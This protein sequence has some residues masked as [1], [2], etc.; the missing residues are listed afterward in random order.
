MM[1]AD[2]STAKAVRS[3]SRKGLLVLLEPTGAQPQW[4]VVTLLFQH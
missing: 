4:T 3:V 2:P 1:S